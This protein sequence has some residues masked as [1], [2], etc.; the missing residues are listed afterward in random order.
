M[1]KDKIR[2]L[3]EK[4]TLIAQGG[5]A[6]ILSYA[7]GSPEA[8][9]ILGGIG[10]SGVYQRVS[11]EVAHRLLGDREQVRVGGVLTMSIQELEKRLQ[12]GHTLRNDNFFQKDTAGAD[13]SNADEIIE[14][15]LKCAQSEYQ[16]KKLRHLAY[17]WANA[18]ISHHD[19][20][21]LNYLLVLFDQLS[22]R[23]LAILTMIGL[24]EANQATRGN[25]W[26]LR[27]TDYTDQNI[28]T[29]SQLGF[30]LG[31]KLRT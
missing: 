4:G 14:G 3:I 6:A 18:C 31:G 28:S 8:A 12:S 21:T 26:G 2:Q 16:E 13:R 7:S 1:K 29:G 10:A 15:V 9:A 5:A 24:Y 11:H 30:V 27:E 25:L 23:Q 22:Y 19:A 20:G 17:F